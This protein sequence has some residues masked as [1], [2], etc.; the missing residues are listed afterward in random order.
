MQR[1]SGAF[2]VEGAVSGLAPVEVLI[3]GLRLSS[4]AYVWKVAF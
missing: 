3:A 2:R 1:I 4:Q